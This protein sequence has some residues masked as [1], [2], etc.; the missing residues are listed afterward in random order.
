MRTPA[1]NPKVIATIPVLLSA[2][3]VTG[4]VYYYG[5]WGLYLSP[6]ILGI[7]AGGLADLD[8]GFTGRLKNILFSMIAFALSSLA[9]QITFDQPVL[10]VTTFTSL[11]FIFTMF[12]AAGNRYRTIAFATLVVAVYTALSHDNHLKWYVNT[13]L[14]LFGALLHSLSSL[15]VHVLFPHRPVQE[16]MADAYQALAAYLNKKADF[17]DPDETDFLEQQ[18]ID[19][20]MRN[21][22]VTTA[23]NAC[24]HSL[25]YRM[26]GQHRHPR[27]TKMLRYFFTAQDIHERISSS[28]VHYQAFAEQ[29]KYSDLI[30]R[31]Q[32]L[33][34]LQA[35]ACQ[36]FAKALR[37]SKE[38]FHYSP[39]LQR[40]TAGAEQ[41][42]QH[43]ANEALSTDAIAP[44]RVQRLLDN[45][46]HVSH[47]LSHLSTQSE[48]KEE[49]S[50][51]RDIK[52]RLSAPEIGGFKGAWKA[53]QK[54][55]S[56]QSPV[57][58]HAV[59]MAISVCICS[60]LVYNIP[61]IRTD[62]LPIPKVEENIHLGY[63][64]L[65][66]AVYVCQPNYSA[67]KKRLIQRILGTVMGVLV[68]T[69][70]PLLNLN[71][72]IRLI[73]VIAML[74]LF[75]LFRTN[76]HSF[77]T[78]FITIQ[79]ILG[80]S[81]AGYDVTQFFLPRVVD[82]VVGAFISGMAVYFLWPDW[83]YLALEKT[84]AAAIQS[85][86]GYLKAVLDDLQEYSQS[87]GVAYRHARRVSHDRAAALSSTLSDMSGDPEKYGSRLQ[88]GFLLLKINY[89]LIGYIAALGAYRNK[90]HRDEDETV[91]L[92]PFFVA[93]NQVVEIM[94]HLNTWTP[95]QFQSALVQLQNALE[96]LRPSASLPSFEGETDSGMQNQ[97]LW[98]QLVMI[99]E[100]L[101]PCYDALNRVEDD[102]T[103]SKPAVQAV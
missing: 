101:Q 53:L 22:Q 102:T 34:R 75:F 86:A 30:F 32:R 82:T 26:K 55:A 27:T 10:L 48:W 36:D 87:D 45:I 96:D 51:V 44:Y 47:Q 68:G 37:D 49:H 74:S 83:K 21:T 59:R 31:I 97:V 9:V 93:G 54:Q 6:M 64:I 38:E 4:I 46:M 39:K 66:T 13:G 79:A 43:Y 2:G 80:F 16:N 63:W 89:S 103:E 71:L 91:F 50:S 17:F 73:L 20:A 58:R 14:M 7:L 56:F 99:T 94:N 57:F 88:D 76:K 60:I 62:F 95:E 19:L 24:R 23:F 8:N 77:S 69:A 33:L 15:V 90:I 78:F 81:I 70:L 42:L 84:G 5:L 18:Q 3:M 40:A 12:G 85:N 35:Q 92:H 41:S 61:Y 11:A 67:T 72:E 98:Q 65:L 52:N 1:I 29:M 100:L 28:H 25:F